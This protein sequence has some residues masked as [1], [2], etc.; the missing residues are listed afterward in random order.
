MKKQ[1]LLLSAL[2]ALFS[3]AKPVPQDFHVIP[4]PADVTLS[5][6][7]FSVK[8]VAVSI[9]PA[10]DELSQKAV[11]RFVAALETATGVKTKAGEGGISFILN[12]NLAAEQYAINVDKKGASVEAS[13]LN[14]FVYACETLKQML[15]PAIYGNK[16]VKADWVLPAVSILDQPRFD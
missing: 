8:G 6:G 11:G 1:I 12:P 4:M 16:K 2:V 14:G 13:A 3:C 15:P 9:D 7:S 5:E 10:M